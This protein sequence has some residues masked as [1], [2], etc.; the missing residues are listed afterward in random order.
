MNHPSS[1]PA[2]NTL[3]L[4]EDI[5]AFPAPTREANYFLNALQHIAYGSILIVTPHQEHLEFTGYKKGVSARLELRD[6]DVL[7]DLVAKGEVGFAEAYMEGR[8]ESPDLTA[9]ITFALVNTES[10][11]H[12]FH[13][14]PIYAIW[15]RVR[16]FFRANSPTGSRRN[17]KAHYDLGNEFY[18][19]W[20]DKS[21]TYSCGLFEGNRNRSLEEAQHAKYN[22]ILQKLEALPGE[23]ILEIGCGWGGFGEVAGRANLKVTGLTLSEEQ[24]RFASHRI[25]DAGLEDKVS[26]VLQDYREIK[27][28]FDH[29]VS[30]GMFEHVGER[31]WP[32]YFRTLKERLKPGGTAMVQTITLDDKLFESL[33]GTT[34][35]IEA[36]IFPG[37][38]LPSKSRFKK[39]A[40]AAG[41]Y[42]KEVFSFGGDYAITLRHWLAAFEANKLSVKAMGYDERFIRMW[43]FY[44]TSCIASFES[45]RTDVMQVELKHASPE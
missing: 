4:T 40:E 1:S 44:L 10:L 34:G 19:L 9:L 2:H 42:C 39:A 32:V 18:R 21:M 27:G 5:T 37:G 26:I 43:R 6:W 8:W 13:G 14:K 15:M 12:F 30:I 20:L 3:N 31:Y 17:V 7:S 22:R 45:G 28:Q 23:T 38:M 33:H 24:A 41:L 16:E 11:E 29:M 35:F 25:K 36:Y